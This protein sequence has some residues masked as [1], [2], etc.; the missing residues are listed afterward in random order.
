MANTANAANAS[1]FQAELP[2]GLSHFQSTSPLIHDLL[3]GSSYGSQVKI[4][5]S[6]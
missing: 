4:L 3:E 1:Y 6:V 5:Y 2:K